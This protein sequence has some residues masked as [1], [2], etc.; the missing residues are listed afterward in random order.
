MLVC[1]TA[2]S[3][4]VPTTSGDTLSYDSFQAKQGIFSA[5]I[6][7]EKNKNQ[8]VV[9]L[10]VESTGDRKYNLLNGSPRWGFD[11][12]F[13]L[14]SARGKLTDP[15]QEHQYL[16]KDQSLSLGS[17][18]EYVRTIETGYC[19]TWRS[20]YR[21]VVTNGPDAVINID[22]KEVTVKT[23]K[24]D[25][26]SKATYSNSSCNIIPQEKNFYLYSPELNEIVLRQQVDLIN[27]GLQPNGTK[28]KLELKSITT[29]AGQAA[30]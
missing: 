6:T 9:A 18:W 17:Q 29:K 21:P 23:L 7:F 25:Y 3:Q 10:I 16:P 26:D 14:T 27:G 30:K 4:V 24:V 8:F 5:E 22:S 20:V 12:D 13:L 28:Y 1:S 11:K 2:F 15:N 19:G